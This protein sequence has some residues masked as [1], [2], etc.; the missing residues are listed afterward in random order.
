MKRNKYQKVAA[1]L[2]ALVLL[3]STPSYAGILSFI[4]KIKYEEVYVMEPTGR[5]IAALVDRFTDKVEYIWAVNKWI[6][7]PP[8]IQHCYQNRHTIRAQVNRKLR[9]R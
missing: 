9:R 6:E 2:L 8:H 7:A 1:L 4:Q 5:E 3:F